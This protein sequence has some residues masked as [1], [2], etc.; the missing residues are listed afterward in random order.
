MLNS[1]QLK[2]LKDDRIPNPLAMRLNGDF[3]PSIGYAF[4]GD[5]DCENL[6]LFAHVEKPEGENL[7]VE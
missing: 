7:D 5:K 1:R 3:L 6:K 4:S 2:F